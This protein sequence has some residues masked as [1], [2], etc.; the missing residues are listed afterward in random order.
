MTPITPPPPWRIR[1]ENTAYS[2][3]RS[4][5]VSSTTMLN[6]NSAVISSVLKMGQVGNSWKSWL[7]YSGRIRCA[8]RASAKPIP[9]SSSHSGEDR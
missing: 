7:K 8:C 3:P 6:Q 9:S 1:R 2:M 5:G 4:F